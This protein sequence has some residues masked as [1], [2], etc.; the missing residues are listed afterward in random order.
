MPLLRHRR[1]THMVPETTQSNLPGQ[2]KGSTIRALHPFHVDRPIA[3]PPCLY[4]RWS[5][6][7]SSNLKVALSCTCLGLD[8]S[9][10]GLPVTGVQPGTGSH[11]AR[12]DAQH[13]T[14][15]T[16]AR[17]WT[18]SRSF[19]GKRWY[20]HLSSLIPTGTLRAE[21]R[22]ITHFLYYQQPTL[23]SLA[24]FRPSPQTRP[25]FYSACRF[26]SYFSRHSSWRR[27]STSKVKPNCSQCRPWPLA[28]ITK[29]FQRGN[30][31]PS[32]LGDC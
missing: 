11:D 28:I 15:S 12:F 29:E 9:A 24:T 10:R 25:Q 19:P 30:A 3:R 13:S 4:M 6:V 2:K 16:L 17:T 8:S 5:M 14:S 26:F 7:K 1:V 22:N 21:D 27:F 20:F 31:T 32:N 23:L 18:R